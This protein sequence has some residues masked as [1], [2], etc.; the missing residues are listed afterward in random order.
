MATPTVTRPATGRRTARLA[1]PQPD[2]ALEQD[3]AHG[4]GD[5][6]EQGVAEQLVGIDEAQH[7][8]HEQ[9]GGQQDEHGR[10]PEGRRQPLGTDPDHDDDGDGDGQRLVHPTDYPVPVAAAGAFRWCS[11]RPAGGCAHRRPAPGAR[12]NIA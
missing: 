7:R 8:T 3:E 2:P 10:D 1:E 11:R 5:H 9:P 6:R 12:R 4:D